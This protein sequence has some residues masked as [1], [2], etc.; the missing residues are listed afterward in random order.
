[1][2]Y[3]IHDPVA[4]DDTKWDS[5]SKEAKVIHWPT[6]APGT[7]ATNP[8]SALLEPVPGSAAEKLGT[9]TLEG[10]VA[11]GTRTAYTVSL[12]NQELSV[13]H[14]RWYC[15]ELKIV[16]LEANDDPRTGTWRNE[17]VDIV[18]GEPDVAKYRPPADYV[19]HHVRVPVR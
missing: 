9:R 10:V 7:P 11:E 17:L 3:R 19:I 2:L 13:V 18:R 12:N 5:T 8:F 15:P 14:E 6:G 16:V 1:M 4:N